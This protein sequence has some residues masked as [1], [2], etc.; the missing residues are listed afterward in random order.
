VLLKSDLDVQETH[1]RS[2]ELQVLPLDVAKYNAVLIFQELYAF[3][4][5][6]NAF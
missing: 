2:V 4:Q 5:F 3:F 1:L 6:L